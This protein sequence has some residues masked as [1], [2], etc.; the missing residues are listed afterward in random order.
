[1]RPTVSV[2]IATYN[3]EKYVKE[4]INSILDNLEEYDEII[5][6]DDGST[7]ET[8]DIIKSL[9]D[10]R[11]KIIEGPRKG[12]K[13]NFANAIE[14]T[15]GD[16]I[17]LADQ[18]DVWLDGKVDKV[19]NVFEE[20]EEITLVVHNAKIVNDKLEEI[21]P[22]NTFEWR[23]SKKGILNN[24][25]KNTYIGCC[26]AFREELKEKILPIP[27]DIEMHDQWIGIINETNSKS[28]FLNEELIEYRRHDS[29]N[30]EMSHYPLKKMLSNRIKL[31][32]R[33]LQRIDFVKN[34]F[35][36]ILILLLIL[37]CG[38]V[39]DNLHNFNLYI[40]EI[41]LLLV[42]G[43]DIYLWKRKTKEWNNKN[44]IFIIGIIYFIFQIVYCAIHIYNKDNTLSSLKT[45]MVKMFVLLP[46]LVLLFM[47]QDKNTFLKNYI[48][49]FSNIVYIIACTSLLF[50][51]AGSLL[52]IIK[53]TNVVTINWGEEERKI[54]SYCNVYFESQYTISNGKYKIR[55][56]GISAE[57]PMYSILLIIALG[58]ELLLNKKRKSNI[59]ILLLTILTSLSTA[60]ILLAACMILAITI[61]YLINV[62]N[63]GKKIKKKLF[64]I[65]S[66]ILIISVIF[67]SLIALWDKMQSPSFLIRLN[68]WV[69]SF[70]SLKNNPVF[71]NGYHNYNVIFNIQG[72]NGQTIQGQSSSV[73]NI[74]SEGGIWL[75]I[76]YTLP[77]VYVVYKELKSKHANEALFFIIYGLLFFSVIYTYTICAITFLAYF[78]SYFIL[79]NILRSKDDESIYSNA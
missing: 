24:I 63:K 49:K 23:K 70:K 16:I 25:W 58:Y 50:F 5:V 79:N 39:Y 75:L 31:I 54:N 13:Q 60:G 6:S 64:K 77:Y 34:A 10:K 28:L 15:S 17:F 67:I 71:G 45:Y 51:I 57:G 53:P 73:A 59:I 12:I 8:I 38:T 1:M 62:I 4:Q 40:S 3:G 66:I 37:S 22:Y 7:D 19:L 74:L 44:K 20:N 43:Y 32:F 69:V 42:I 35:E 68:D 56:C 55:N 47:Q 18:D 46:S 27:N 48:R 11:I 29:N 76:L 2:A 36:Y 30:S 41:F 14:H 33:L 52:H 72:I 61:R 26:M 21:P 65:M 9:H 78:Y